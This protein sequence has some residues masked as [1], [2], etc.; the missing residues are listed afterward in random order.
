MNLKLGHPP[1]HRELHEFQ[2]QTVSRLIIEPHLNSSTVPDEGSCFVNG[3]C[4]KTNKQIVQFLSKFGNL[5]G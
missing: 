1:D 3:L 5:V 2:S 4:E